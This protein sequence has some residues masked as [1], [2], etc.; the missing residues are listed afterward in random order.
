MSLGK[1]WYR[2]E[3]AAEK[4]GVSSEQIQEWIHEGLV[5][6]ELSEDGRTLANGDDI[7]LQI[8]G[9]VS[10]MHDTGDRPDVSI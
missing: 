5:R 9:L 10:E 7:S 6:S 8:E 1:T 4:F 2:V 3:K